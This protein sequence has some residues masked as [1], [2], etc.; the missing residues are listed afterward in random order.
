MQNTALA[1]AARPAQPATTS[2][3]PLRE[4]ALARHSVQLH[5]ARTFE[6]EL[7]AQA[8]MLRGMRRESMNL[9]SASL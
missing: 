9:R 2:T 5:A 8:A 4:F 3:A 7:R 6:L 1:H